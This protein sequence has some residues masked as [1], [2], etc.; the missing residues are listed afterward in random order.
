MGWFEFRRPATVDEVRVS[1]VA[2]RT[3]EV[4]SVTEKV[5]AEWIK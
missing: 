4:I 1:M 2:N 3:N 5:E